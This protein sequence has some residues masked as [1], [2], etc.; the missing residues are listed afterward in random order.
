MEQKPIYFDGSGQGSWGT[1]NEPTEALQLTDE[2]R[3]N[4]GMN[5]YSPVVGE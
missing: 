5:P 3:K 1:E 2:V 4:I